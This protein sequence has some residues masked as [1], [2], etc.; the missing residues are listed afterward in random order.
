MKVAIVYDCLFPNTVGGAERWYRSLA[1]R[2]GLQHSVTY[3][4]RRQW[5]DEGPRT[6]FATIAV[7]PGGRLYTR[8]GRR[9]IWPPIRFGFGVL[10]HLLRHGRDYDVVHSASFPYFSPLA[11]WFALRL[12]CSSARLVVDWHEV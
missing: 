11:A 8:E 3:L 1:E 6:P 9:R 5:G 10:V 7:A 12:T 4:T 2:L